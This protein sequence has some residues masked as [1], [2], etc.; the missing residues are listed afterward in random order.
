MTVDGRIRPAEV[1][2]AARIAAIKCR[3]WLATYRGLLPD[4]ILDGL[5]ESRLTNEFADGIQATAGEL[6]SPDERL[7]LVFDT[8]QDVCGYVIAGAYRETDLVDY[9]EVYALYVDPTLWGGGI[10]ST[11]LTAAERWLQAQ[12]WTNAALWVL[13][14]NTGGVRF[15]EA[16]R[17]RAD[18]ATQIRPVLD[19]E[20]TRLVRALDS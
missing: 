3:G 4:T 1:S 2:D 15:Y 13:S 6:G 20:E 12:G 11:L 19:A 5:D 7:F 10:G 16:C 8:G 9:G 18:G 14:A 17:W